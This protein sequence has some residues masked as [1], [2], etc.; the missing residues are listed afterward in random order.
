MMLPS[1]I[2]RRLTRL[3]LSRFVVP[4]DAIR[5]GL[6]RHPNGL[7]LVTPEARL[8][9]RALADRVARTV[10]VLQGLGLQKGGRIDVVVGDGVDQVVLRLA[11]ME[12]GVVQ[13]ALPP[14]AQESQ[15]EALFSVGLP[16]LLVLASDL[17]PRLR[18]ALEALPLDADRKLRMGS[19]WEA[20]LARTTPA[21]SFAP[22]HAGD[23]AALGF[24]S[25]TTGEPKAIITL[26]GALMASLSLTAFNVRVS[27]MGHETIMPAMPLTGAGAGVLLPSVVTGATLV[28]PRAHDAATLCQTMRDEVVTRLFV[29]PSQLIDLLDEPSFT[30]ESLPTLRNV[31]YGT[32]PMPVPKLEEALGRFGPIFQQG[33]GMAEVLPPVSLLQV[34]HHNVNGAIAS[35]EVLRSQGW[36][37]PGV[38][39][40]IVDDSDRDVAPGTVGQVLV[41]SPTLFAGYWRRDGVDRSVFHQ[42]F[43]RTGDFGWLSAD[44]KLTVLDRGVDV[45]VRQGQRVFPRLIEEAAHDVDG[46]KEACLVQLAA[47]SPLVLFVSPRR[48]YELSGSAIAA[49]LAAVLPAEQR[50]DAVKVVPGIPRSRLEKINR[51]LVRE[52][53][54]ST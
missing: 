6:R 40:R 4:R 54:L 3:V 49:H 46:V 20:L 42:G 38:R 34:E 23:G 50:P 45:A 37:V 24:T 5:F 14:W 16:D 32:A 18:E 9:Y 2:R 15:V 30:R 19:G 22:L 13:G 52:S 39:V 31:I 41:Q 17:A 33:Y 12:M 43:L 44:G 21:K 25:G 47:E 27:V 10:G 7:A 8:T 1:F 36:V 51:K 29:T 53:L 28:L 35:R 11:A 48:G 26:Q